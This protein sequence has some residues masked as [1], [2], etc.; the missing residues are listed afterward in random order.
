METADLQVVRLLLILTV[1]MHVTAAEH[2]LEK[3]AQ[4]LTVLQLM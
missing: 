1:D 4:R 2:F 3:T